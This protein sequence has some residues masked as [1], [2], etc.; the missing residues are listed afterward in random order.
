MSNIITILKREFST[1]VHTKGF[2]IGTLL[3]PLLM[4]LLIFVPAY[5]TQLDTESAARI[6]ISDRSSLI[7]SN[8]EENL[9]DTLSTGEP[10]YLFSQSDSDSI[11]PMIRTQL[12]DEVYDGYLFIPANVID[13]QEI[14]FYG[15]NVANFDQIRTLRGAVNDAILNQKTAKY[16]LDRD[17]VRDLTRWVDMKTI[18][19]LK[20]EEKES[21]F[22]EDFA[23]SYLFVFLLYMTILIYGQTT[24]R[25]VLEE[26]RNRVIEVLLSSATAKQL[27]YGKLIGVGLVGLTQFLIWSLLGVVLVLYSLTF[28]PENIAE[29]INLDPVVIVYLLVFFLLGYFFYTSIIMGL[30]SMVNSDE[31]FQ[32]LFIPVIIPIIIPLMIMGFIIKDPNSSM[33]V[34]T[35]M[36]P[37]FSPMLMLMRATISDPPLWQILGSMVILL[38][39][40][41]FSTW[42]AAKI[43]RIGIL[44]YGKRPNLPELLRWMRYR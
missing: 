32:Q 9:T 2:V 43:Y 24:G 41:G 8:L 25:A 29:V 5:L 1:R 20:G 16:A 37:F 35:S 11:T 3:T 42:I 33:A 14:A 12:E 7:F 6:L 31:E 40:I 36:V 21:G 15:K 28:V 27:M 23:V 22:G 34:W 44:M 18:K 4:G 30:A 26:K 10:A 13:S 38:I 39:S 19:V 17:I